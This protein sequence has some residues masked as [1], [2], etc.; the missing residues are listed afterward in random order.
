MLF[1]YSDKLNYY[2]EKKNSNEEWNK[3]MQYY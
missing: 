1:V 3:E 2:L